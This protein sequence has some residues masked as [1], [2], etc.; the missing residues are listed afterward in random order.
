M[1]YGDIA[2]S[3]WEDLELHRNNGHKTTKNKKEHKVEI[4]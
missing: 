2:D 3:I 4:G 1:R